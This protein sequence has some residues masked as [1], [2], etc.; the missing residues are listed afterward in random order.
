MKV[1]VKKMRWAC[2]RLEKEEN[3]CRARDLVELIRA[4]KLAL[5]EFE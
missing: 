2:E 4:C 3:L 5:K 1:L